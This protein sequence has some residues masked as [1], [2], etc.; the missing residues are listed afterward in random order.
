MNIRNKQIEKENGFI[1]AVSWLYA[2]PRKGQGRPRVLH[3]T[4]IKQ[5]DATA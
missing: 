1:L 3:S 5:N 2:G 4:N